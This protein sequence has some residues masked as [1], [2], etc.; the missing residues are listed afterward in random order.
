MNNKGPHNDTLPFYV[1][2]FDSRNVAIKR[3]ADYQVRGYCFGAIMIRLT[4]IHH[5]EHYQSY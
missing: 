1:A 2:T 4:D 3:D 5:L